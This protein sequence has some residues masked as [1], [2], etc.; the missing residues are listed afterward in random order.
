MTFSEP[1]IEG[2]EAWLILNTLALGDRDGLID[3]KELA[4]IM[5]L[6][7]DKSQDLQ[8]EPANWRPRE[9]QWC[10]SSLRPKA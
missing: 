1:H 2:N 5:I 10:G 7:G 8:D 3:C 4:Y 9:R 6:E